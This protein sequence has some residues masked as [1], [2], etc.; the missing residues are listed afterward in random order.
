MRPA[1]VERP[2]SEAP[3]PESLEPVRPGANTAADGSPLKQD[4][5][6]FKLGPFEGIEYKYRMEKGA[7]MVYSWT[8]TGKVRSTSTGEPQGAP[9]GLRRKLTRW[10]E[11]QKASGL[12]LRADLRHHGWSGRT[13]RAI[14]ITVT[15][16][17]PAFYA[18]RSEFSAPKGQTRTR[19]P[20]AVDMRW[21]CTLG[22]RC[23]AP[24]G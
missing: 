11:G 2:A 10:R 19:C 23:T 18:L 4:T 6:T 5:V 3:P 20:S 21:Q 13:S 12:V 17:A 22:Y 24:P 8:S 16:P 14:D 1:A 15:S 7:S 9:E